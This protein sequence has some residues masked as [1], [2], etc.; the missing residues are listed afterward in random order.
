MENL[1]APRALK[2]GIFRAL[3]AGINPE[4][5]EQGTPQG[6]VVSPLLANIALNGIENIHRYHNQKGYRIT[7]K[8][9]DKDIVK[10]CVRYADDMV[11]FLRPE[12]DAEEILNKI[13]QFL[14]ERGLKVSEKKTKLTASTDG[15]D[16]L[17]WHFKVYN[18]GRLKTTPSEDNFKTFRKKVKKVVNNSN[19]GAKV[20]AK[21]LA[22]IVRG[23]RNYHKYCDMS[24]ARFSLWFINHRT[25]KVFN[26]EKKQNRKSAEKLIEQAFPKV[27]Y[28]EGKH[29]KVQGNKSPYDGDLVYWSERN[30]KL[31]DGE[32]SKQLLRQNHTCAECGLKCTSEE[33][34]HLHHI[35]GNHCN[36]KKNNLVVIHESCHDYIHMSKR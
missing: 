24:G 31:Y 26:K 3:K 5:P 15:F 11:L 14:A 25:F 12:D 13:S 17:G 20:K 9:A 23:W 7:P 35:D 34:L 32:T 22:L 16:F 29:I 19:Y 28:S 36:W 1:I 10:A 30:S 4:F 18:D 33:R 2:D 8:T 21:K 6:G 27:S